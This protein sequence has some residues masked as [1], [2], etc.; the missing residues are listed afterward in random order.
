[1]RNQFHELKGIPVMVTY[2]PSYLCRAESN[3]ADGGK[4]EKRKVW[5]DMLLVMEKI[6]ISQSNIDEPC[7]VDL[8]ANIFQRAESVM[9][10]ARKRP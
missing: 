7:R 5:E 4:S 6:S 2:H 1:M 8:T 3:S 10:T 9:Q